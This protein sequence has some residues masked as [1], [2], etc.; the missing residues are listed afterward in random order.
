[1]CAWSWVH[2]CGLWCAMWEGT[3]ACVCH[4]V[5]VYTH[6]RVF[7]AVL[8]RTK[9]NSTIPFPLA[10]GKGV[11]PLLLST[12]CI[13]LTGHT[14]SWGTLVLAREAP[15][16]TRSQSESIWFSGERHFSFRN[17]GWAWRKIGLSQLNPDLKTWTVGS[18]KQNYGWQKK[19]ERLQINLNGRGGETQPELRMERLNPN[20]LILT[21]NFS[22]P[23]RA[24]HSTA[25]FIRICLSKVFFSSSYGSFFVPG[26]IFRAGFFF[27]RAGGFFFRNGK[28]YTSSC[29]SFCQITTCRFIAVRS[30]ASTCC[31]HSFPDQFHFPTSGERISYHSGERISYHRQ[32]HL[33]WHF[34]KVFKP[35]VSK[36]ECIFSLKRGKRDVRALSFELWN[37]IRK[38]H[39][40]LD[41]LYSKICLRVEFLLKTD[42]EYLRDAEVTLFLCFF[43]FVLGFR[44]PKLSGWQTP[45]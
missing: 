43:S 41:Q 11:Q 35:Q 33:G 31:A 15:R 34:R 27:C 42:S 3:S 20:R 2:I 37:S 14:A 28:R 39:P 9:A 4:S 5:H 12:I 6:G 26:V 30:S 7:S 18:L 17:W 19:S 24:T 32:S 16:A 44:R 1:M 38:C 8:P 21:L 10:F 29:G 22:E 13:H 25:E 45:D 40:N 36:L 23:P